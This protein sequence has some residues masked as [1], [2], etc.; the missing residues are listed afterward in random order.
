MK[1]KNAVSIFL[2]G[3]FILGS[4]TYA[5][6]AGNF[7]PVVLK[8]AN[9][10]PSDSTASNDDREICEEINKAT[11]GRVKVELYTDSSL[12]DYTSIFEE[13][14]MGTIDMAHIT[15][16][17]TYDPKMSGAMLPYLGSNYEELE[18][19]YAPDNYLFKTV[20]ESAKKLGLHSFG[21]YCEGFSGI[22]VTKEIKDPAIPGKEK[23][24]IVRI[25]G[26]DNFALPA[27]ELGFRTSTIAYSDTYTSMQTGTVN[28]WVGGPPNLNYLYFRDVIK[29]YYHYQMTQ[30][31]TQIFMNENKFN[32]LLPEDQ[33]AI[34]KIIQ[35]KCKESLVLAKTDEEKYMKLMED[36]GIKVIKFSDEERA[37]F[38][39]TIREKVWPKLTKH[40]SKK[41]MD[42]LLK[43]ME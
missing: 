21:F 34:T 33:V 12:G 10:H 1:F 17:E 26:L 39:K 2:T 25:P 43:S 19:A 9:Q 32:S 40:T 3:F 16:V 7:K 30:E 38:A 41:F 15:A 20:S 27:K 13:T 6:D 35:N 4:L 23:D 5:K 22:G 24:V 14:M 31:A 36:A 11:E 42:N 37:N 18:K 29:Y 28:G 8:F